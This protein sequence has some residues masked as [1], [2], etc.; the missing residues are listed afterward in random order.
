MSA[1]RPAYHDFTDMDGPARFQLAKALARQ[2]VTTTRPWLSALPESLDVLDLGSG[3]GDTAA[4]LATTFRSVQGIEPTSRLVETAQTTHLR[5]NLSFRRGGVEDVTDVDAF[6]LVVLDNVYE[7]LPDHALGLQRITAALR[8]GGV[9]YLLTP[10]RL[11]PVEAHYRLPCL[12]W[13]PLPLANRYLRVT[14]RGTDYTDAS[15]APTSWSL[16]REL[17]RVGLDWRFV[18]PGDPDAVRM[19]GPHYRLGMAVLRR[20]PALWA[21]SK[22][23]LV[24]A[25]KPRS[26]SDSSH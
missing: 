7:H 23:L 12:A 18:L 15:Y 17:S 26:V 8:P 16:G 19:G 5:A 9:L 2:I 25:I 13:L 11:W 10:N 21:I 24:I 6:D 4:E 20:W 3:Y 14:R 1:D 22:S